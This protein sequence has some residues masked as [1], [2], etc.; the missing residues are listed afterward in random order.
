MS[1]K[2]DPYETPHSAASHLG[3]RSV[4][5]VQIHLVN[6]VF[7]ENSAIIV[8]IIIML[9]VFTSDEYPFGEPE[10]TSNTPLTSSVFSGSR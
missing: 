10:R 3:L 5:S 1:G 6:M 9:W 4:L 2:P 8:L 7:D